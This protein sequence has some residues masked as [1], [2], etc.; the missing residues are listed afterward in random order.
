MLK[1]RCAVVTGGSRGLDE[2][3]VRRLTEAGAVV[4]LTGRGREA[5][6]RVESNVA[7]AGGQALGVQAD[8]AS[9][10]DS[11]KVIDQAMERFGRVDIL[12]NNAAV[13]PMSMFI[14]VSEEVW[15]QT[16]DTDLKGVIALW[17]HVEH[18]EIREGA[19]VKAA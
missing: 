14:E 5:L 13:F 9:L 3:I 6:R 19:I 15:E 8:F 12:V 18:G 16:V 1:G 17:R 2:A 4:V 10:E 11:R 7:A